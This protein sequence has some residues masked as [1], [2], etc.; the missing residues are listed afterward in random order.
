MNNYIYKN[1]GY[2]I[3]N[4]LLPGH[5]FLIDKTGE[6][7]EQ[8]F[9][10]FIYGPKTT[11]ISARQKSRWVQDNNSINPNSSSMIITSRGSYGYILNT[12]NKSI[13]VSYTHLTLP[14]R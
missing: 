10:A 3:D 4:D 2:P 11:F 5:S 13:A 14:T 12:S 1:I 8:K 6:S 9:G 7:Y